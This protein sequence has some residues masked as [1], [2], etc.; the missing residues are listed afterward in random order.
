MARFQLATIATLLFW[1]S[2]GVEGTEIHQNPIVCAINCLNSFKDQFTSQHKDP[3][4]EGCR[5][6]YPNDIAC[7]IRKACPEDQ[8]PKF[9]GRDDPSPDKRLC[10]CEFSAIE[11]Q[12]RTV[13]V[14]VPAS[15]PPK[16]TP[17]PRA[18]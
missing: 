17:R 15:A 12:G 6:R 11:T 3:Y 5:G 10:P 2:F 7:C 16:A 9:C 8:W 18:F 13:Y 14:T 4:E 1:K